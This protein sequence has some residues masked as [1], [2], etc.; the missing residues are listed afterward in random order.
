M[1]GASVNWQDLPEPV[2][3]EYPWPGKFINLTQDGG[4]SLR[5]HYLDEGKGEPLL[6]VHGNP[7]WS[8]YW[9]KLV[10]DL[11]QDYRCIAP[12]HIGCGLSEKPGDWSYRLQD[13]IDNLSQLMWCQLQSMTM[14][15][16]Q[17]DAPVCT[18]RLLINANA[19]LQ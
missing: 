10:A 5:M 19:R 8:F 16:V 18:I 13:H 14:T 2:R 11:G 12:D 1:V 3:G 17:A 15:T 7:T 6:M 4:S 9:R